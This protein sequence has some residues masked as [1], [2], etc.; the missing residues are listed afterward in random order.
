MERVKINDWKQ[1][2]NRIVNIKYY[3]IGYRLYDLY[4]SYS[5]NIF[6]DDTYEQ[7]YIHT[8]IHTYT[9]TSVL[10]MK[11]HVIWYIRRI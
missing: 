10:K 8:Y 6:N 2:I 11:T 4:N 5:I 9:H 3:H 1:A 7:A